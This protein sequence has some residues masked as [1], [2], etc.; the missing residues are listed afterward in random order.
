MET[1]RVAA[2]HIRPHLGTGPEAALRQVHEAIRHSN[3]GDVHRARDRHTGWDV[4][5]KEARPHVGAQPG[6]TEARDRLRREAEVLSLPA[7]HGVF[8]AGGHVF[9]VNLEAAVRTDSAR[10]L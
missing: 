10:A 7:P 8:E 5:L 9:L 1:P 4:L 2:R 3:R 6:G